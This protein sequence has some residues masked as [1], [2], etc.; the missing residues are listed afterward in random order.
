MSSFRR[1]SRRKKGLG[2]YWR[3]E[4][5][6]E[7]GEKLSDPR[8]PVVLLR[9]KKGERGEGDDSS[10]FKERVKKGEKRDA[11]LGDLGTKKK[12]KE[13]KCNLELCS[14][15]KKREGRTRAIAS[16]AWINRKGERRLLKKRERRSHSLAP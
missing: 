15:D 11:Y 8:F 4:E 6:K 7:E 1:R 16:P 10:I 13:K 12:E 3:E 14:R 5:K 9:G 2:P